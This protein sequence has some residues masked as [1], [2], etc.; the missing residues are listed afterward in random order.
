MHTATSSKTMADILHDTKTPF[1]HT[2]VDGVVD[3]DTWPH[4]RH[5]TVMK[6]SNGYSISI[7]Y[8]NLIYSRDINESPFTKTCPKESALASSVEVAIFD[9]DNQF[10]NFLDDQQVKGFVTPDELAD[11]ILWVRNIGKDGAKNA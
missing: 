4:Q 8:G 3:G 7:V 9:P 11:I 2:W 1:V 6:F 5:A 10:V